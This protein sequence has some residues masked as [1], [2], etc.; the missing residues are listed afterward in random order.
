MS[1]L[2]LE[3]SPD[4]S[5]MPTATGDALVGCPLLF[6]LQWAMDCSPHRMDSTSRSP[7]ALQGATGARYA[8]VTLASEQ[9]RRTSASMVSRRHP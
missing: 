5:G 9:P 7:V 8:C 4:D 1:R 2:G 3:L 6:G